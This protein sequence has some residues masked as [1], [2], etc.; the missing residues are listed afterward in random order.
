MIDFMD[1]RCSNVCNGCVEND[2]FCQEDPEGCRNSLVKTTLSIEQIADIAEKDST[3][4]RG[5][6]VIVN[7]LF[8]KQD[9]SHVPPISGRFNAT[10]RAIRKLSPES[11]VCRSAIEYAAALDAVISNIVNNPDKRELDF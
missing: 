6:R 9:T 10:G 7:R 2:G 11:W 8:R 4:D 5:M 1:A 3:T